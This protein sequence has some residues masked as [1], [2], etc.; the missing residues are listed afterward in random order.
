MAYKCTHCSYP[1]HVTRT[2]TVGEQIRRE[3]KC[4]HP[5]HPH[6]FSTVEAPES[7]GMLVVR[8][9]G[10]VEPFERRR[11]LENSIRLAAVGGLGSTAAAS[12]AED[13]VL[14]L[15]P[16]PGHPVPTIDIGRAVIEVLKLRAPMASIRYATVF[17]GA[18]GLIKDEADLADWVRANV[19][20]S[21]KPRKLDPARPS[22]VIKHRKA[23]EAL[24][25]AEDFNLRKLWNGLDKAMKGLGVNGTPYDSAT[26]PVA[27]GSILAY[28]LD[29]VRGQQLVSSG[30]LSGAILRV[31]RSV[32]P[33]AYLR[34][35]IPAKSYT[36]AAVFLE[37]CVGITKFPSPP[38]DLTG[39]EEAG[40]EIAKEVQKWKEKNGI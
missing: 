36:T 21:H 19:L 18:R 40:A 15:N 7:Q 32:A 14:R 5:E 12:I 37:E 2:T 10:A 16:T 29:E 26:Y 27:L 39:Y 13:V 38:I 25:Q 33:L 17:L 22:W 20:T 9:S 6:T 35:A 8:R 28:V 31:L 11:K 24:A 3:R 1:S 23:N 4:D 30:Q 34:Y